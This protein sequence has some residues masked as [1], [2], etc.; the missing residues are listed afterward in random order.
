MRTKIWLILL[1]VCGFMLAC[2]E[3]ELT[4]SRTDRNWFLVEDDPN[5]PLTHLRYLIYSEDGVA[6]FYNDTI[7]AET[8]YDRFGNPYTHY[9]V[10]KV[11]YNMTSYGRPDY[12][13]ADDTA[14]VMDALEV[15]DEYLFDILPEDRRPTSYLLVD[16]LKMNMSG[17]RLVLDDYYKS[18]T[19]TCVGNIERFEQMSDSAR[20]SFMAE[21]AGLE[22]AD[23]LMANADSL[24]RHDFDSTGWDVTLDSKIYAPIRFPMTYGAGIS[25]S[26]SRELARPE[27]FGLLRYRQTSLT[28]VQWPT[29]QQNYAAFVGLVLSKTEE[30][31]KRQYAQD[32]VVL[33]KYELMKQMMQEMGMIE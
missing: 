14:D 2:E 16:S 11:G 31:V 30:E 7:G 1:V 24:L 6:C 26:T 27:A 4:P 10:L 17:G 29:L 18:I 22:Y 25:I 32:T 13:L 5:N 33:Q 9:E 28:Y 15:M 3:E 8:R 21:L 23:E 12:A 20:R 19:T